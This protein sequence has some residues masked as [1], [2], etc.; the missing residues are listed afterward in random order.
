MPFKILFVP[1]VQYNRLYG[2][3]KNGKLSPWS[4]EG[5]FAHQFVGGKL[6]PRAQVKGWDFDIATAKYT[7]GDDL[8]PLYII[9]NNINGVAAA[10]PNTT[11]LVVSIHTEGTIPSQPNLYGGRYSGDQSYALLATICDQ[12]GKV[13]PDGRRFE[14]PSPGYI[15]LDGYQPNVVLAIVEVGGDG[16]AERMTQLNANV[17]R[18]AD[19]VTTGIELYIAEHSDEPVVPVDYKA[20]YEAAQLTNEGLKR[21]LDAVFE[22]A[23]DL[24]RI[25]L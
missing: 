17:N 18:I 7:P 14:Y 10:K 9:R 21:K 5:D 19:G 11:F 20:L 23:D 4:S 15:M 22:I 2:P 13:Y 6:V 24:Q 12:L 8:G 3:M 25:L 16:D 1:S